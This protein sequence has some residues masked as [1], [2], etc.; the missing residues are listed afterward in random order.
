[1]EGWH[2]TVAPDEQQASLANV[3]NLLDHKG[4]LAKIEVPQFR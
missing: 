2:P 1:M 3:I 4:S